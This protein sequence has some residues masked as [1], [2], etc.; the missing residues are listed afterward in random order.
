VVGQTIKLTLSTEVVM[1]DESEDKF[2]GFALAGKDR[3][4]FPAETNWFT[5]G[6][7]DNRNRPVETHNILVLSSPFVPEPVHYRY[8]WARNP[9]ANVTNHRQVPLAAQRSDEW[10]MEETPV[11]FPVPPGTPEAMA[12]RPLRRNILRELELDETERRIKEAEATI[13][14]LKEQYAKDRFAWEEKKAADIERL[15]ASSTAL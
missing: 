8:A 3:R 4:F 1:K 12:A 14:K 6:S 9:M 13:A 2:I 11:K 7:K 10:R 5:D 15:K